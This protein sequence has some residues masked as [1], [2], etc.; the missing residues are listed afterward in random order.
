[1]KGHSRQVFL[2]LALASIGALPCYA[3]TGDPV[4]DARIHFG[5]LGLTPSIALTDL[6]VDSNVF[7][8]VDDPRRDFTAKLSPRAK[9]WFRA[10]RSRTSVA[11]QADLVYFQ[12]YASQRSIDSA[13]DARFEI[14]SN[15]ITPWVAGGY[16]SGR[17]RVGPEIDLRSRLVTTDVAAGVDTRI[18][19]KTHVNLSAQHDFYRYDAGAFFFGSSL[20]ET[21]NHR[22]DSAG[23]QYRQSWSV[24]TT[25]VL[26]G[27]VF[28]DRFEFSPL[29]NADSVR[30]QAGFDLDPF[31]LVSGRV[32]VGYRK[33]NGVG[34]GVPDYSGVVAS[35]GTGV[36]LKGRTRLE[37][38]GERDVDYSYDITYPYYV[39]TGA[40][41]TATPRLTDNWDIQA[42]AG[43]QRLA[44]A[45]N[46]PNGLTNRIDRVVLFGAGIGYRLGR[47][48]RI[49]LNVDRQRRSSPL[50]RRDYNG[51]RIGTSVTYGT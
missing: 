26:Q 18:T 21:L 32:R 19:A 27:E 6:G 50:Q 34:G 43:G 22:T 39:L 44:Y 8:S 47:D 45:T 17:Q 2:L 16:S 40:T 30:A 42:R 29:R 38:V 48:M 46:D 3:Q 33:L 11:A 20:Q 51:Y 13:A 25:F 15:R 28:R 14:L 24:L 9:S 35:V 12:K 31:A 49:G 1:M 4:A 5:P 7:N 10:G 36:T 41:L 37:L 23:V